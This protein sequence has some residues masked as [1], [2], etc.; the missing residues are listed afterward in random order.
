MDARRHQPGS[1]WGTVHPC[2]SHPTRYTGSLPSNSQSGA[3]SDPRVY[4][5]AERT[6]LAWIRTGLALMG[7]GFVVAR[8]GLFLREMEL[9]QHPLTIRSTRFT[10]T[11]GTVLILIG[12]IVNVASVLQHVRFVNDLKSGREL[13]LRPAVL[14]VI[15]ALALALIG[16]VVTIY[17]LFV[18]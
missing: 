5:A 9:T 3:Q 18:R 4:L 13:N 7:F 10:V 8:F 15:I 16:L 2:D 1:E 12:V 11:V 14:A 17:L 6:F